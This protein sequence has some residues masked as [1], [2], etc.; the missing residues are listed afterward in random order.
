M[1][2]PSCSALAAVGTAATMS[3]VGSFHPIMPVD[4]GMTCSAEGNPSSFATAAHTASLSWTPPGAQTF[5][6]L[7]FTTIAWMCFS[8]NRLRPTSTGAPG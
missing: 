7:L 8:F 1:A 5:D 2:E 4:E 3:L 6:I